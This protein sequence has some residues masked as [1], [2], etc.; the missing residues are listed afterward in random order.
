MGGEARSGMGD[1]ADAAVATMDMA[2]L[3]PCWIVGEGTAAGTVER[4]VGL[5]LLVQLVVVVEL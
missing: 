2:W 5:M 4:M 1:G 3:A